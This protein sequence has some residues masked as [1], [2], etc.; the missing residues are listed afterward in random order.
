MR[1]DPSLIPRFNFDYDIFDFFTGIKSVFCEDFD[2]CTLE[3]VFK[4]KTFF[5][6]NYGR[7][8]LYIILK[9]LD[10][11][12]KSKIGVPLYCCTVVFD[13]IINSGYLP[14]FIDINNNYTMDT[15]DLSDKIEDLGAII[16]IHTF[17][18]PADM[19]KIKNIA[20]NIPII[21]DCSHSLFSKYQGKITGSMGD[22]AIF[23]LNKYLSAGGGGLLVVNN[24]DFLYNIEKEFSL[25]EKS[26]ILNDITKVFISYIR[27]FFYK[28]PFFG[29][30]GLPIGMMLENKIDLTN[31][32]SSKMVIDNKSYKGVA[33][34]KLKNFRTKV[35]LQRENSF[36]LLNEL[37]NTNLI[38]PY[39]E[40]NTY[41]N[42]YLFPILVQ[43]RDEVC[44]YLRDHGVDTTKLFS[45]THEIA[46]NNYGYI[47][48]CP[49]TENVAE[50]ILTIPNHYNLKKNEVEKIAKLIKSCTYV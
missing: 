41:C 35:E 43:N 30:F 27:A 45:L 29:L 40:D 7:T 37:K 49:F 14:K 36:F 10:L 42:Y 22:V 16:V 47:G 18:R 48:D 19:E 20:K 17:G 28:K 31:K 4:Q 13:A 25:L 38:L 33:L 12:P 2:M 24:N 21:E 34:N 50:S 39:E 15:D 46:R 11:P 8:A 5:F 6:T 26:S 32:K 23:S 3:L 44:K 9:S 1:P